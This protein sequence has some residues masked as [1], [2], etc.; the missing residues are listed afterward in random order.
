M[1]LR[2]TAAWRSPDGALSGVLR[3][4]DRRTRAKENLRPRVGEGEPG[5]PGEPGP[6]GQQGPPGPQG[7]TGRAGKGPGATV[8]TTDDA[9]RA[10]WAYDKAARQ[11]PVIGALPVADEALVV[12]LEE[13]TAEAVTVR[14]WRLTNSGAVAAGADVRIH[15]TAFS[16]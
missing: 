15:L 2:G 8:V 7:K 1:A 3:D 6:A 9:G 5:P 11:P 4:L 10:R 16:T 12:T 14:A 13:V